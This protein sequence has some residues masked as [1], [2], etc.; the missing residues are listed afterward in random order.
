MSLKLRPSFW[1]MSPTILV[2]LENCRWVLTTPYVTPARDVTR[3]WTSSVIKITIFCFVLTLWSVVEG[4]WYVFSQSM[5][6]WKRRFFQT[7]NQLA[8]C[9]TSS[10]FNWMEASYIPCLFRVVIVTYKEHPSWKTKKPFCGHTVKFK[11]P[12]MLRTWVTLLFSGELCP[13]VFLRF[14]IPWVFL[15]LPL[16]ILT[17]L[18]YSMVYHANR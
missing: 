3:A 4:A 1:A 9:W 18:S 6:S 2:M 14:W 8:Q 16:F 10:D 13:R 12:V 17:S 7:W 11:S 15:T 5:S